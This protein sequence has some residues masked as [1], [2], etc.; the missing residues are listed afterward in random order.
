M[1]SIADNVKEAKQGLNRLFPWGM[2]KAFLLLGV[3]L[4]VVGML[5][6]RHD[7]AAVSVAFAPALF[8]PSPPPWLLRGW[9]TRRQT[10]SSSGTCLLPRE[11]RLRAIAAAAEGM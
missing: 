7:P 8:W 1:A 2:L 11:P 9:S 6:E 4:S 3:A 5:M 10:R